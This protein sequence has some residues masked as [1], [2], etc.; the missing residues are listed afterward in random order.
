MTTLYTITAPTTGAH[1]VTAC[2]TMPAPLSWMTM[3]GRNATSVD[4]PIAPV[5]KRELKRAPSSSAWV[6]NDW[7]APIRRTLAPK[8]NTGT[9]PTAP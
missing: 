7:R 5:T 3:Y 4:T 6:T 8:K 1:P 2:M 9:N